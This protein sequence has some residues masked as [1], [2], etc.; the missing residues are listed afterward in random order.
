MI[1]CFGSDLANL[2]LIPGAAFSSRTISIPKALCIHDI[3]LNI[4]RA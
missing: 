4:C 3:S 1:V 2:R